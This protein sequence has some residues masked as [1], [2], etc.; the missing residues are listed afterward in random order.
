MKM[1]KTPYLPLGWDILYVSLGNKFMIEAR[2]SAEVL[3]TDLG[4]PTGAVVVKDGTIIGRGAN[5]SLFHKKI[6]CVR[7]GLRKI[8]PVPS[9]K[10]YWLCYGCSPK[11]HA[12]QQA[13]LDAKKNGHDAGG[14]DLYLWGHWWCCESCWEKMIDAKIAR[15]F[16]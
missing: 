7:K 16:L 15:V 12:E 6:G 9:G 14:A 13:L 3:S 5:N 10:G 8:L 2:R 1:E 4:H 11:F